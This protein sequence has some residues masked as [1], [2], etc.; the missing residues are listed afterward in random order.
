V[1]II[2]VFHC[3]KKLKIALMAE[4]QQIY[5]DFLVEI[6]G[7]FQREVVYK[8]A[9]PRV[10]SVFTSYSHIINLFLCNLA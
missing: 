10:S 7:I 4:P 6:K 8:S 9:M 3:L 1:V 2:S 5:S